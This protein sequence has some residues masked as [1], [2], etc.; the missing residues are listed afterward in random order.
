[1]TPRRLYVETYGCQMNVADTDLIG[2]LFAQGGFVRAEAPEQADVILLNTCAVREKPEERV[3]GRVAELAALKGRRPELV[4]GVVGC[5]AEHLKGAL[6]ERAP[7]VDVIAGPDSYRRLLDLCRQ[8]GTA[9]SAPHE[10]LVDVQL[11]RD[12]TYEGLD[13]AGGGDGVSGF[14]TIQRGCDKFCTFCVVPLTRGRERGTSPGEV[15]RQARA[16]A[17]AG[18][19]ELT[20]LGQTV[21]SYRWQDVRF[22]DLLRAVARTE[23]I[24][25]VRFT[26]PYPVDFT[27]DVVAAIAEEPRVCKH[28]HLPL[29]TGSDA[30]LARMRRGYDYAGFLGVV[31]AL[32]QAVPGIAISTDLIVGFCGE[33]EEDHQRTLAAM[34]EIRF[35]QAYMFAYSERS[36]TAAARRLPDDVP[37]EVKRR[38]LSEVIQLQNLHSLAANQRKVGEIERVLI[39]RRSRKR[40]D[41]L[42]ARTD[43]FKAVILPAACGLQPGDWGEVRID[44]ATSATLYGERVG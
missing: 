11:S 25:R 24:A 44:R 39:H 32:R 16:F 17:A 26:S 6:A 27:P 14:I 21:N 33:T 18:Y 23:G 5:M 37:H 1:V 7:A 12:E 15:L 9:G 41:Q 13:A 19:R 10:P 36:G 38:R 43:S 34:E 42:L 35:D 2:G 4:L 3:F 28:V 22:S 29:Q 31:R 8:A 40:A 20:L 30:V